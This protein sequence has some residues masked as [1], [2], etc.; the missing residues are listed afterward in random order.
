MKSSPVV[1]IIAT[2]DTKL[3]EAEYLKKSLESL[4]AGVRL[5]DIGVL[6]TPAIPPD[7]PNN[8]VAGAAG[9]S[10][11]QVR[12]SEDENVAM[13]A[14]A[15]GATLLTQRLQSEKVI[16]AVVI[17][18]GSMGTDL[19]LDVTNGL[20]IGVPKMIVST[21]AFSDLIPPDRLAPDLMMILWAGGLYG[22][23][24]I[25]KATLR[26]A[27]GAIY[28]AALLSREQE[29]ERPKVA[30]SSFGKSAAKWMVKLVPA[31]ESR[32]YEVAVFHATGMGGRAM[33]ALAA[34]GEFVAVMDFAVQEVSNHAFDSSISAGPDR[35]TAAGKAG[36]PQIV[37]PG[38]IDL[39]DVPSWKAFPKSLEGRAH[40]AHNR[41]ISSLSLEP[42]ERVKVVGIIA[43]KL[44][45]ATGPCA[46]ILP[47]GGIH[48]WD[49]PGQILHDQ[50]AIDAVNY[51]IEKL[52]TPVVT[53]FYSLDAHINDDAFA[54]TALNIFDNW[55]ASGLIPAA[56]SEHKTPR[57]SS[58]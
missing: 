19:A 56:Q 14:M 4:G 23:N 45:Q 16:D 42:A 20:P 30:I 41:L 38:F 7:Y 27:A 1:L 25:C 5:M 21:V 43:D 31:L 33:E 40:H 47:K 53:E 34:R 15:K 29:A 6:E 55:V 10:I 24:G 18:G 22:L 46:F 57:Q 54:D 3:D 35:L 36:I 11:A 49:R 8:D 2:L 12:E 52:V 17:L 26:Q 58:M 48:E 9:M 28:G 50:K 44:S 39:V 51:E 32:G 37:A 13:T